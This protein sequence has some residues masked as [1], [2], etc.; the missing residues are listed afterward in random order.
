MVHES[1]LDFA[2]HVSGLGLQFF[3]VGKL[4]LADR[5]FK[6]AIKIAPELVE[7]WNRRGIV[8]MAMNRSDE[9]KKVFTEAIDMHSP[10]KATLGRLYHNRSI[11]L[12]KNGEVES[13]LKD[14]IKS[15]E[16]F[17]SSPILWEQQGQLYYL[18]GEFAKAK[19]S[20][21]AA[22]TFCPNDPM[23]IGFCAG[24]NLALG[25]LYE[26]REQIYVAIYLSGNKEVPLFHSM[27]DVILARIRAIESEPDD[28]AI[29][30]MYEAESSKILH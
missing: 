15:V 1:R 16:L 26:A 14:S 24:A 19:E 20:F 6:A 29:F 21:E 4:N 28:K 22:L 10:D 8:L 5:M 11:C 17:P 7:N 3:S 23:L 12:Q 30:S 2:V 25:K 13:A 9:A 18:A 27:K